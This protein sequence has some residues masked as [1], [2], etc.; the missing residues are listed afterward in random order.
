MFKMY[1]CFNLT[2]KKRL[3]NWNGLK[4]FGRKSRIQT[5]GTDYNINVSPG[6]GSVAY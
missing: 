6:K 4:N 2:L 1:F 3:K 5:T